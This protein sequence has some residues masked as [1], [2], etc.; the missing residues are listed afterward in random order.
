MTETVTTPIP[1]ETPSAGL[2]SRLFGVVFSPRSAYSV[3]AEHPRWFGALA[4]CCLIYI[5]AQSS[6]VATT[7][8]QNAVLDQQLSVMK[9]IGMN[10]TDQMVQQMESRMAIAPY[11]T[12]A[13]LLFF[14][15]LVCAG[16]AGI[17]LA[18]FTAI[19]GGGATYRQVFAVSAHSMIIGAIQQVFN[20]PI[21]YARADMSSPTRLSVFFPNLDEMSFFTYLLSGLDLFVFW[22]LINLSI[23]VA[24]LYKRRTGPVAAVLLGIYVTIVVI[25]AAVRAF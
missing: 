21:N 20:W 18:V 16:V 6:F 10:V 14:M 2:A 8:G 7:V 22:S 1:D 19:L 23:G 13:S 12:A 24:V 25:V 11:T 9:A 17:L 15:P 3:V 4:V 5:A